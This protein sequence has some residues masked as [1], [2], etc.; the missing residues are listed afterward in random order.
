MRHSVRLVALFFALVSGSFAQSLKFIEDTRPNSKK[1]PTEAKIEFAAFATEV[2]ADSVTTRILS[3]R[4]LIELDPVARPFVHAGAG[5][6]VGAGL[7]SIV[8]FGGAWAILHHTHHDRVAKWM[9]RV[10]VAGEGANVGR[11]FDL[12]AKT[13]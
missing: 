5:G 2:A 11:Q 8:A 10:V 4:G 1:V 7:L 9:L 12:L 3:E 6:Q 13:R